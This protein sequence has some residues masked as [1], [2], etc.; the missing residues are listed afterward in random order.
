M[1]IVGDV[2]PT[3]DEEPTSLLPAHFRKV[4]KKR[5][6]LA[7]YEHASDVKQGTWTD[8]HMLINSL[9]IGNESEQEKLAIQTELSGAKSVVMLQ[10]VTERRHCSPGGIRGTRSRS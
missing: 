6:G 1:G 8:R 2:V 9:S 3:E 5:V 7:K 4:A 10:C